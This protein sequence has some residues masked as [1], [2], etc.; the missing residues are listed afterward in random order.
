[1]DVARWGQTC[2][3]GTATERRE[4]QSIPARHA[5]RSGY[6]PPGHLRGHADRPVGQAIQIVDGPVERIHDPAD[7]RSFA[8]LAAFF[9]QNRIPWSLAQYALADQSLSSAV[10]LGDHIRLS[11]LGGHDDHTAAAVSAHLASLAPYG[12]AAIQQFGL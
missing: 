6:H 5:N 3:P 9:A 8:R 2:P 1:M 10:H 12:A 7:E 4:V 11:L